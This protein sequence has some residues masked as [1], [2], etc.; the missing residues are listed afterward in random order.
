MLA[1]GKFE[2]CFSGIVE[3][4]QLQFFNNF[5][6]EFVID[7]G[8]VHFCAFTPGQVCFEWESIRESDGLLFWV[9]PTRRLTHLTSPQKIITNLPW[10]HFWC[11]SRCVHNKWHL[12]DF[13]Q[14][15]TRVNANCGMYVSIR[16]TLQT[17]MSYLLIYVHVLQWMYTL[18]QQ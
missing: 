9:K 15:F 6:Q 16:L 4:K 11:F 7:V 12:H 8:V 17:A 2:M 10:N 3:Q 18:R 13:H 14:T 5:I 1:Y